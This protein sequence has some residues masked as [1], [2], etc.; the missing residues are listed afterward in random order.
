MNQTASIRLAVP[1]LALLLLIVCIKLTRAPQTVIKKVVS[2]CWVA[3]VLA[4]VGDSLAVRL[5]FWHYVPQTFLF[6]LPLE[7][8][9]AASLVAAGCGIIIWHLKKGS[10]PFFPI[11][12]VSVPVLGFLN[13]LIGNAAIGNT[14]P[15]WDSP[16][17][18]VA[19]ITIWVII[20]IVMAHIY[21]S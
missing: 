9:V 2:V 18:F 8:Y 12:L 4:A 17:W 6:G 19:D 15:V 14:L 21:L 3:G 7:L 20:W 5:G 11:F 16:Y 1:V 10:S 13:D